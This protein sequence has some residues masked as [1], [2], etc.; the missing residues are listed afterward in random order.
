MMR[1]RIIT[2]IVLLVLTLLIIFLSF[3]FCDN[4]QSKLP[5][6]TQLNFNQNAEYMPV[7]VQNFESL[8]ERISVDKISFCCEEDETSV[9]GNN[10]IP[11]LTNEFYFS[12][13]GQMLYGNGFTEENILK[14]EKVTVIGSALALELFFNTNAVG[15]VLKINGEEYTICGV[16]DESDKIIDRISTDGKKRVYIPYTCYDGYKNCGIDTI[17]YDNSAMSAPLIEQMNLS[18]YYSVDF[19]EKNKVIENFRHIVCLLLFAAVSFIA[20]KIWF[21]LCK[22]AINGIKCSLKEQYFF[23]SL[24]SITKKYFVLFLVGAGIPAILLTVFF[25]FDFSIFIPSKYIPYDNIFDFSYYLEKIIENANSA[26][27]LAL[28]GDTHLLKL[29][30]NTFAILIPHITAVFILLVCA[31]VY[32]NQAFLNRIKAFA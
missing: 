20:M 23:K 28:T 1:K 21:I 29:F 9:K 18:Q 16:L 12:C 31:T 24:T 7:L 32:V 22:W 25:L 13:F 6:V 26:N 10:V 4:A 5:N 17:T 19:S 14:K 8:A 2:S 30:S 15:K 27:S 3:Y 11:V